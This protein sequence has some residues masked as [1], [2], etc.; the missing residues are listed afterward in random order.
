MMHRAFVPRENLDAYNHAKIFGE[1]FQLEDSLANLLDGSWHLEG[2]V[3]EDQT[4][5]IRVNR[6]AELEAGSEQWELFR[7]DEDEAP[8]ELLLQ[9]DI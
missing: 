9:D 3:D 6:A 4:E 7:Y 1:S 5:H 2:Y 8:L